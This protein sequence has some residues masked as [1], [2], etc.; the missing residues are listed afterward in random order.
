MS[1]G[2]GGAVNLTTSGTLSESGAGLISSHRH[3]DDEFSGRYATLNGANT[4]NTFNATNTT[5]GNIAL[6]NTAAPL[7]IT[8]ISETGGGN[9]VVNNTGAANIT[10]TVSAGG[11]RCQSDD[12][13]D[14][15]REWGGP[16]LDDRHTDDEFSGR[17]DAKWCQYG[18]YLQCHQHDGWEHCTDQHGC[19]AHHHRD[20]R[21]WWR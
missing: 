20:Q 17:Y 21:K 1:A 6:T 4:V 5:G 10:G 18:E 2:G 19:A 14:A 11:G 15:E 12:E 9:V 7:T 3:T 8:G 16:D 13:R